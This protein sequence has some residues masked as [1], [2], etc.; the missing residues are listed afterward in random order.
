MKLLSALFLS[1]GLLTNVY[2]AE[3]KPAVATPAVT[4]ADAGKPVENN[5]VKKD[6]NGKCPPPPKGAKPK[7]KKKAA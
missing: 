6:K 1:I 4:K 7:P 3:T 2:A 5:C